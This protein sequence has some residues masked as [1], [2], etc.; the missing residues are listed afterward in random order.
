MFHIIRH[1]P[2]T[3]A[4]FFGFF[5]KPFFLNPVAGQKGVEEKLDRT[6]EEGYRKNDI[7]QYV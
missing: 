2:D 3:A 7:F 6:V 5:V 1:T 4:E